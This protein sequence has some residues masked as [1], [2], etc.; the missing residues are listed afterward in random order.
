MA[1]LDKI[2]EEVELLM[3]KI[4]NFRGS[5]QDKEY[6]YLDEMLTRK[7][8]EDA[9]MVLRSMRRRLNGG[10]HIARPSSR[11]HNICGRRAMSTASRRTSPSPRFGRRF[12]LTSMS[13][14]SAPAAAKHPPQKPYEG[15]S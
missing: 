14:G 9:T 12:F 7:A 3:E 13:R 8:F 5:K 6:L 4:R 1:K 11:R 10:A 15:C 2:N